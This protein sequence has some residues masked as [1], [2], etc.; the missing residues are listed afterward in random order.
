MSN[1]KIQVACPGCEHAFSV[2]PAQQGTVVECPE[3]RGYVDVPELGREPTTAEVEEVAFLRVKDLQERQSEQYQR[4]LDAD[5]KNLNLFNETL[6]KAQALIS[7]W[8]KLA[9]RMGSI[10]DL[11]DRPR[12]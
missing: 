10:I 3:C 5:E 9:D 7:K 11:M 1:A 12:S 4:L 6:E 8:D 2:D